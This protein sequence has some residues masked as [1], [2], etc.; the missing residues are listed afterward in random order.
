MAAIDLVNTWFF[1]SYRKTASIYEWLVVPFIVTASLL[2][3]MLQSLGMGVA[4]ST[5]IFVAQ[6]YRSE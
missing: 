6:F 3:G 5:F 4:I 2:S 1:R